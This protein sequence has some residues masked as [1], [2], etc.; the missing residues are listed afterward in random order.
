[1]KTLKIYSLEYENLLK[2]KSMLTFYTFYIEIEN[3]I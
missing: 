2:K 3:K 1:M